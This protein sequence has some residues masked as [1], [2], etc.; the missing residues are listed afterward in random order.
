[1]ERIL[2]DDL[3][4]SQL[5]IRGIDSTSH[6]GIINIQE[7]LKAIEYFRNI[8]RDESGAPFYFFQSILKYLYYSKFYIIFS[9]YPLSY[10]S[11]LNEHYL[12]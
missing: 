12:S 8:A 4:Y 6:R 10:Y 7:P 9:I 5:A 3:N 1:M 2:T 11:L